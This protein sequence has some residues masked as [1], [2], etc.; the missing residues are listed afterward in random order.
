MIEVLSERPSDCVMAALTTRR[1]SSRG[2][3]SR[4]SADPVEDDDGVVNAV[5]NDRQQRGDEHRIDLEPGELAADGEGAG[6]DGDVVQQG[7]D[8]RRSVEHGIGQAAEGER[9]VDQ[10]C[11]G[12]HGECDARVPRDLD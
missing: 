2:S 12:G 11:D 6:D 10:D 8:R 7:D 4:F 3:S 1:K 9:D 5:A